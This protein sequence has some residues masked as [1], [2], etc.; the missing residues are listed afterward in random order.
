[1]NEMAAQN[2]KDMPLRAVVET[3][4]GDDGWKRERLAC[5]HTICPRTSGLGYVTPA[6]RR[7]C[8]QCLH[9]QECGE[10]I[11]AHE[12]MARNEDGFW[13]ADCANAPI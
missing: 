10:A 2:V 8:Y 1:M 13:H 11:Y 3:F 12:L 5:G 7:R 4:T 9:C 6:K